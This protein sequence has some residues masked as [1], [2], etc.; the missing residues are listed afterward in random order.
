MKDHQIAEIVNA[1]RDA[2]L[3]H[4]ASGQ[5]RERLRSCIEPLLIAIAPPVA[6]GSVD[7]EAFKILLADYA[8]AEAPSIAGERST[9]GSFFEEKALVEYIDSW[10][11]QQR[12][13]GRREVAERKFI[14]ASGNPPR[15]CLQCND[16]ECVYGGGYCASCVYR[17]T[18]GENVHD[19][20]QRAEKAEARVK[21]LE[22]ILPAVMGKSLLRPAISAENPLPPGC[23]C[24]P[25]KCSAP[26]IMGR[27]TACRDPEKASG[28]KK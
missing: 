13:A 8:E 11:A 25:G 17:F 28:I 5:L 14:W 9:P 22:G 27:Q 20:R 2:A 3:T 6:A 15:K 24:E 18:T 16:N 23:Y 10:G 1:L 21:E 19:L 4:H 12:E 26:K 7:T